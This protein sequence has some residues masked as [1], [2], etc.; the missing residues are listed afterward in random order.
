VAVN[1]S[2]FTHFDSD[3]FIDHRRRTISDFDNAFAIS[4]DQSVSIFLLSRQTLPSNP[5]SAKCF[6]IASAIFTSLEE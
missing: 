2:F 4:L 3:D 5:F 1:H 6:S